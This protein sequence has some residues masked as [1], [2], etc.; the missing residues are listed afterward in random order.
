[1]TWGDAQDSGG[2]K[3]CTD[4]RQRSGGKGTAVILER[5]SAPE[6]YK[7]VGL[8]TRQSNRMDLKMAQWT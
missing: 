3:K 8:T 6:V 4:Q 5:N 1:M 2:E 7:D